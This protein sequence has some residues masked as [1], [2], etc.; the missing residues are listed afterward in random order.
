[1]DFGVSNYHKMA[2]FAV[3]AALM[4]NIKAHGGK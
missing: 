3:C 2:E 4:H 1:M